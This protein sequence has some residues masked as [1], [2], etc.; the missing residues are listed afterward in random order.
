MKK[1][2]RT[3]RRKGKTRP[4]TIGRNC[5]W[6]NYSGGVAVCGLKIKINDGRDDVKYG[7]CAVYDDISCNKCRGCGYEEDVSSETM[8]SRLNRKLS[9]KREL[10][11]VRNRLDALEK[12]IDKE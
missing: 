7:G 10:D 5:R 12:M 3:R 9:L 1:T 6:L 11:K 2:N 4:P 8:V